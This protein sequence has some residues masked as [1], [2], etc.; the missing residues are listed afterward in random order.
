MELTAAE[1]AELKVVAADLIE[2]YDEGLIASDAG[3]RMLEILA[4]DVAR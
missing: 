4:P 1:L 3:K 2:S